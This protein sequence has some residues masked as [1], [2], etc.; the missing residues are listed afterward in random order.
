M[1]YS[2][3]CS[4]FFILRE[5]NY[6]GFRLCFTPFAFIKGINHHCVSFL[7]N[8][9]F[10]EYN[11]CL[12]TVYFVYLNFWNSQDFIS[13]IV[14]KNEELYVNIQNLPSN[15]L[16][17]NGDWVKGQWETKEKISHMTILHIVICKY[18]IDLFSDSIQQWIKV[19]WS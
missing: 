9:P 2:F 19:W 8:H 14:V 3:L 16:P 15:N 1:N 4:S 11:W 10:H 13:L 12:G 5:T 6:V 17:Y 18:V 7:F